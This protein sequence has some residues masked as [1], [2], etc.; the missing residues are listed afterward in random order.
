MKRVMYTY[1]QPFILLIGLCGLGCPCDAST[2]AF[3]AHFSYDRLDRV[4]K[5]V[6]PDSTNI[7]SEY[8]IAYDGSIL[9]PRVVITDQNNHLSQQFSNVREQT[10]A[11]IDPLGATTAFLYDNIGQLTE[12]I[13]PEGHSTIHDYDMLGRRIS[14]VHPSAGH[15][16]W[17]YNPSGNMVK[18]TQIDAANTP[19]GPYWQK[20]NKKVAEEPDTPPTT[21]TFRPMPPIRHDD[22][23]QSRLIFPI[24]NSASQKGSVGSRL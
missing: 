21:M 6:F 14:R 3:Q 18:Q 20:R 2:Y 5:T 10:T 13:D 8:S 1:Y 24:D 15:T 11:T 9:R 17:E 4:T 12:S 16:K 23:R 7:T 22:C 19:T